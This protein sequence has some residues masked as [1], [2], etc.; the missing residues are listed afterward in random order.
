MSSRFIR[1]I[2]FFII[3][4]LPGFSGSA[5]FASGFRAA[6]SSHVA[7]R[8]PEAK[9]IEAY[10]SQKDFRYTIPPVQTSFLSQ[11]W[12]Y[13]K[14]Q[15][16]SWDEFSKTMPLV[17]KVLML[18]LLIFILFIVITKTQ[19]FQLFYSDKAIETPA[20]KFSNTGDQ[21]ID[22]DEAI[23]GQMEQRQ[24]RL[25]TRLLYLKVINL[26]RL[27]EIIHFSKEKTNVDYLRDLTND[28]LKTRFFVITSIYNHVWYGD[29]EIAEEQFLR[30]EAH[31]QSFYAAIDVKE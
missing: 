4:L 2:L 19:L 27:K 15:F 14:N 9:F 20:F 5:L 31:F 8:Q 3:L 23:R 29:V 17:Y 12:N 24:Y 7:V 18:G 28:D 13:I 30:F 6:D 25:A 16:G 10:R 26:L 21:P 22:Y 1:Q 11:L